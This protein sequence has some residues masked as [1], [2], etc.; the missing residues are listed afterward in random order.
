MSLLHEKTIES[1]ASN[2]VDG[3]IEQH[4]TVD[5]SAGRQR[6]HSIIQIMLTCP[7]YMTMQRTKRRRHRRQFLFRV[8]SSMSMYLFVLFVARIKRS[9]NRRSTSN[10]HDEPC[11]LL[12]MHVRCGNVIEPT[13][14]ECRSVST[15]NS[16]ENIAFDRFSSYATRTRMDGQ[17]RR[18]A[19][20]IDFNCRLTK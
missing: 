6:Q 8:G 7:H 5:R 18:C 15:C 20:S 2:D 3:N 14:C 1:S 10:A 13:E 9:S 4:A 16:N 17:R 11:R 19:D 12:S